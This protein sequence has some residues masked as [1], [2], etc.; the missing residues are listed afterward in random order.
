MPCALGRFNFPCS[1]DN[2]APHGH[3]PATAVPQ[4]LC[5]VV[6]ETHHITVD[7][8]VFIMGGCLDECW[9]KDGTEKVSSSLY[10]QRLGIFFPLDIITPLIIG[11][12]FRI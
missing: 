4:R 6:D 10:I 12:V 7:I 11:Y 2:Q 8:G 1:L 3:A 9:K 5:R